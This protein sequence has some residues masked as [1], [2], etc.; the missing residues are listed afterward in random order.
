MTA[1]ITT[2]EAAQAKAI[3]AAEELADAQMDLR[4]VQV[5][6]DNLDPETTADDLD[7][8]SKRVAFAERVAVAAQA[9]AEG[10]AAREVAD[11]AR[12]AV[13]ALLAEHGDGASH[14][15]D[16]KPLVAAAAQSLAAAVELVK[17]RNEAIRQTAFTV[18]RAKNAVPED[19]LPD[20]EAGFMNDS[21]DKPGVGPMK[22]ADVLAAAIVGAIGSGSANEPGGISPNNLG[23][24][25]QA[26]R[27]VHD[28][29]NPFR[30][31]TGA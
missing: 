14:I 18:A 3:A 31:G 29:N 13:A 26:A 16:V 28:D 27:W 2:A 15:A 23:K 25:A 22:I 19:A 11:D 30:V 24:I 20:L 8:A 9:A 21:L 7:G 5:R 17:A 6:I 1:A 4:K 12:A 10:A